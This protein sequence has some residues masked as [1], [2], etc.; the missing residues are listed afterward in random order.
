MDGCDRRMMSCKA[1]ASGLAIFLANA[2]IS[3]AFAGNIPGHPAISAVSL[4]GDKR[5]VAAS[6]LT[7][8]VQDIEAEPGS[9]AAIAIALPTPAELRDAG[10]EEGAFMLIR[11][12]P[13]GISVS[14]GMATGRIWVVPLRDAS[15][16][17]LASAP[18]MQARFQLG[19]HL[20]G[21]NNRVLAETTVSVAVEPRERVTATSTQSP[22][23]EMPEPDPV[24][25]PTPKPDPALT[26]VRPAV[27]AAPLPAQQE[28]VLLARG[29]ELL[30]QGGIAAAR[31]LFEELAMRGSG[32]GALALA[33][34]FDPAFIPQSPSVALA[35]NM[36]LALKWYRRAAELGNPDAQRL[37]A[38]IAPG[39]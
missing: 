25:L 6:P 13:E 24:V 28:A 2:V 12:I 7:F 5:I 9:D 1:A 10:A 38:E 26:P 22:K 19:F 18:G 29:N 3:H 20:I 15:T 16:L 27:K 39:R 37:L 30:Q 34:C 35:P 11:N 8:S 4:E 23:P 33:R 32:A 14:A 36:G 17:R 21:P 31:L